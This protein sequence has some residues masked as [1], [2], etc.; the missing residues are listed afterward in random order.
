[1]KKY[2]SKYRKK[3]NDEFAQLRSDIMIC[4]KQSANLK[5]M[6]Q[7]NKL[8]EAIVDTYSQ[9]GQIVKENITDISTDEI[10]KLI[11][12]GIKIQS[13]INEP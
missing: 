1:M 10:D 9:M 7:K 6:R 4:K 8:L 12:L 3:L 13:S 11:D 2:L 5:L